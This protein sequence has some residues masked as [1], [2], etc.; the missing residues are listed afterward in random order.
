MK[1]TTTLVRHSSQLCY[2]CTADT[3]ERSDLKVPV[4]HSGDSK[5][6]AV[7]C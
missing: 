2:Y 4:Q 1:L 3:N 6:N 5:H 7:T